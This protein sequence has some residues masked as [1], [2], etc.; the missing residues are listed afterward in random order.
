MLSYL[1]FLSYFIVH[2]L[3]SE[4]KILATCTTLFTPSS[5]AQEMLATACNSAVDYLFYLPENTTKATLNKLALSKLNSSQLAIL[6]T[7]CQESVKKLVCSMI[8]RKCPPGIDLTKL[9]T[10]NYNIYSDVGITNVPLP[11]Q[12]PCSSVC[13]NVEKKCLGVLKLFNTDQNCSSRF[14]YAPP[15]PQ[16]FNPMQFDSSNNGSICNPMSAKV[17]VQSTREPYLQAKT[18]TGACYGIISEVYVPP[19]QLVNPALAPM[20]RPFLV[21]SLIEQQLTKDLFSRLPVWLSTECNSALRTYFCSST[22]MRPEIQIIGKVFEA[23]NL[24]LLMVRNILSARGVNSSFLD[25]KFYLPS[26]PHQSVCE[27]YHKQCSSFISSAGIAALVPNCSSR[28]SPGSSIMKYPKDAQT[29]TK[30]TLNGLDV[31]FKTRP[32]YLNSSTLYQP[33]SFKTNCPHGFVVPDNKEDEDV[34][35]I[36][37]SGCAM[38]CR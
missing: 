2:L 23:N 3:I 27:N 25:H 19:A 8:Y 34:I 14:Q 10:Y 35:W 11:F 5:S 30:L 20:Q 13:T 33:L 9:A 31:P 18:P 38:S 22:L 37:G 36:P 21:Q 6:P 15:V 28:V 24:P 16:A 32:N 26:Y 4:A 29:I 7:S 12:R 1:A 17:I